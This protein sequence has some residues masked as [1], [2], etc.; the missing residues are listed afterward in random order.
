M[1]SST[2]RNE[3]HPNME[4]PFCGSG[5]TEELRYSCTPDIL[6]D[7]TSPSYLITPLLTFIY[8]WAQIEYKHDFWLVSDETLPSGLYFKCLSALC[9]VCTFIYFLIQ[10]P[11]AFCVDSESLCVC[12][13]CQAWF[14]SLMLLFL[15]LQ[16]KLWC[17]ICRLLLFLLKCSKAKHVYHKGHFI[18]LC[19]SFG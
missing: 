3:D 7:S 19:F 5:V 14:C 2:S 8:K 6:Y 15:L 9:S 13:C 12:V 4:P 1:G 17:N 16:C 10:H 18:K 11:A